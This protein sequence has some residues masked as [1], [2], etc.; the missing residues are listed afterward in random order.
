VRGTYHSPGNLAEQLSDSEF[1]GE[2]RR[3]VEAAIH[4]YAYHVPAGA[5]GNPTNP[6]WLEVELR[7][8]FDQVR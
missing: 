6:Y 4:T 7:D 2:L 8:T 3:E 1:L 5:V